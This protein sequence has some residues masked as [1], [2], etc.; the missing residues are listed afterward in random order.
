MRPQRTGNEV[1]YRVVKRVGK[2]VPAARG[3]WRTAG[4]ITVLGQTFA[5]VLMLASWADYSVPWAV[6]V[7][8]T[9]VWAAVC[10]VA[11]SA[12]RTG[13]TR[14][15]MITA[16][17]LMLCFVDVVV[18]L[19]SPSSGRLAAAGWNWGSVALALLALTAYLRPIVVVMLAV[20]HATA[21]LLWGAVSFHSMDMPGVATVV[22]IGGCLL[23]PI[24]G[25][26]FVRDYKVL[27]VEREAAARRR[28][29]ATADLRSREASRVDA[30]VR[31]R[32]LRARAVP[33]LSA[34]ADDTLVPLS[35]AGRLEATA[36][37]HALRSELIVGPS[38]SWLVASTRAHRVPVR[39]L[40][41]RVRPNH[42]DEATRSRLAALVDVLAAHDDWDDITLSL[43]HRSH[44]QS[45]DLD[46]V[47]LGD[48]A[49]T[50]YFDPAVRELCMALGAD[51]DLDAEVAALT[52]HANLPQSCTE[53]RELE[54]AV[55][56]R[57][58]RFVRES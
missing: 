27:R 24:T 32:R 25:A 36:L 51:L 53:P 22:A 26:C 16:A 44:D 29:E 6:A 38:L 1:G 17:L 45:L 55:P 13:H 50:A 14:N 30:E 58:R 57:R 41:G 56:I 31:L 49:A 33:L 48:A 43:R 54:V 9:A 39:V 12:G 47:G 52:V 42:L 10:T 28:T 4:I 3:I 5:G 21:A 40:T 11:V 15:W 23:A 18:P 35:S 7:A 37:A 20:G 2:A 34:V 8:W 19:A 46:L